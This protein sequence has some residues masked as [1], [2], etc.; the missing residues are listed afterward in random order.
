MDE[1]IDNDGGTDGYMTCKQHWLLPC[2]AADVCL[3]SQEDRA[4]VPPNPDSPTAEARSLNTK[5]SKRLPTSEWV[6]IE[7]DFAVAQTTA[8]GPLCCLFVFPQC[9]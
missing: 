2:I 4:K 7:A 1:W 9:S 6:D 3:L 5:S 8:Q